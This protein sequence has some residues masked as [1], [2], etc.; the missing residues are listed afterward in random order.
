MVDAAS[1]A[2]NKMLYSYGDVEEYK[3]T[4][5]ER[6]SARAIEEFNNPDIMYNPYK[7]GGWFS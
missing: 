4:P 7:E 5:E 2:L 6:I 1:Q 3:P